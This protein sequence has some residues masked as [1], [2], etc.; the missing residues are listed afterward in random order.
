M[1]SSADLVK[2]LLEEYERPVP[3]ARP[4]RVYPRVVCEPCRRGGGPKDCVRPCVAQGHVP[5]RLM[6]DSQ[7]SEH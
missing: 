1:T 6:P 2:Q 4:P 5:A 7:V 3:P